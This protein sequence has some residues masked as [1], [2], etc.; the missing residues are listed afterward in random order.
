MSD[1]LAAPELPRGRLLV[2]APARLDDACFSVPAVRAL[3]RA[4]RVDGL[5]VLCAAS[6]APLWRG[7]PGIEVIEFPDGA[8][9][10]V[11]RACLTGA[12]E[13]FAAALAWEPSAASRGLR[14]AGIRRR[15]GPAGQPL[16]RDLSDPVTISHGPGPIS[17][18]VRD[19]LLLAAALG[20][21]PFNPEHFAP[22]FSEANPPTE[23]LAVAPDSDFGPSHA[24]PVERWIEVLQPLAGQ[25]QL[26]PTVVDA[27]HG[28][29]AAALAIALGDQATLATARSPADQLELLARHRCLAAADGTLPHLAAHL[30]A[31][32]TVLFGPN[33]P[34]WRRPL[35]KRHTI[36]RRHVECSPCLRPTCPLDHRC[37]RELDAGRVRTA[38]DAMLRSAQLSPRQHPV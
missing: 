27:G 8:G 36:L 31:T 28:P 16:A 12:A 17:H 26:R 9:P 29:L 24:W 11:V 1:E 38:V 4:E 30:G 7:V 13:R 20:A 33:E 5:A 25:H 15:F 6:Q 23:P 32:C 35:G 37:M 21:S 14:A 22:A 10:R 34:D 18:R 3:A 19:F 2:A